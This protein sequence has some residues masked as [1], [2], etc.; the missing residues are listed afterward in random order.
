M[1]VPNEWINPNCEKSNTWADTWAAEFVVSPVSRW[2]FVCCHVYL[3]LLC[4]ADGEGEGRGSSGPAARGGGHCGD[5]AEERHEPGHGGAGERTLEQ[6]QH[7]RPCSL[8]KTHKTADLHTSYTICFTFFIGSDDVMSLLSL[9]GTGDLE[10]EDEEEMED[11]GEVLDDSSS[12]PSSTLKNYPLTCKVLYSYKVPVDYIN[13]QLFTNKFVILTHRWGFVSVWVDCL[14]LSPSTGQI[15][16]CFSSYLHTDVCFQSSQP[17]ELTIEEQ[18]ILEVIDDGDMEDWV[19]VRIISTHST[20]LVY[21]GFPHY[22]MFP[23]VSRPGTAA[24]RSATSR[25]NTSS[26]LPPT[27]CWA[28]CSLW[29]RWT[30]DP[31]PPVT[32]PSL[33]PSCRPAPSTETPAVRDTCVEKFGLNFQYFTLFKFLNRL[34][35]S[36]CP[37]RRPCTTTRDRRT[38][39]CRFRKAPSSASW[40]ERRT[41][42]TASGRES[43]TASSA[44]SRP[45]WWRTSPPP[46]RMETD[47]KTAVRRCVDVLMFRDENLKTGVFAV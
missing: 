38:T 36:Q 29:L 30:P 22:N 17:D 18:E 1:F 32:P 28:C 12:S 14:S 42:T 33:K 37:L 40:A 6:P 3:I 31:T 26:F 13:K 47:K 35:L 27:A 5:V 21:C 2:R 23:C 4:C 20:S 45:F 24:D 39:S 41:R 16:Y 44:S 34:S 46:A 43:S 19:K 25:R 10:P 7:P 9:Q 8:C 11:S 15:S